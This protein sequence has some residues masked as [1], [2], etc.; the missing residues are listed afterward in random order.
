M[1]IYI[2]IDWLQ[3][4]ISYIFSDRQIEYTRRSWNSL[5]DCYCLAMSAGYGQRP[6]HLSNQTIFEMAQEN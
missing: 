2:V 5:Y 4:D 1:P 3:G 6:D